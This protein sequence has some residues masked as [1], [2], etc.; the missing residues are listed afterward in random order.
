ALGRTE[1]E[2]DHRLAG[3]ARGLAGFAKHLGVAHA[4]EIDNDHAYARI[5]R[6]IA[7]QI[8]RLEARLVAGRDH[9]TD[10]DAAILQ[11]LADRH[12]DGAGLTGDRHRSGFHGDDAIVDIGEQLFTRAEI[13]ETVRPGHRK[14]SLAYRLLGL[15]GELLAFRVL[16]SGKA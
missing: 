2:R 5:G 1:L 7:H 10:A 8:R 3:R 14:P 9:V 4:F 15:D 6:E 11:R 13:A 16:Q 12:H